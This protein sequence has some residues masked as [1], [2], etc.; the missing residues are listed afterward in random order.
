MSLA[1][2]SKCLERIED[3]TCKI[4]GEFIY[5]ESRREILRDR[6]KRKIYTEEDELEG[7]I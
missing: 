4:Q 2:C 5:G 3:C 7:L 6:R 1:Y